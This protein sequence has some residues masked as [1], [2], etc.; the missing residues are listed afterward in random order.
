MTTREKYGLMAITVLLIIAGIWLYLWHQEAL[1][2]AIGNAKQQAEQDTQKLLDDKLRQR[3]QAYSSDRAQMLADIQTTQAHGTAAVVA[4]LNALLAQSGKQLPPI[5]IERGTTADKAAPGVVATD[6]QPAQKPAENVV[7]PPDSAS[8]LYAKA[9]H[10]DLCAKDLEHCNADVAD[11]KTKYETAQQAMTEQAN[12]RKGGSK[13]G[14]FGK[15][16]GCIGVSG[17]GAG[18]G[19]LLGKEKGAAIGG[20]IGAG[21]CQLI[22]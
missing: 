2:N 22:F 13:A 20:G 3:D 1:A 15:F 4:A 9:K 11:W 12:L 5:V 10:D 18:V 19:A 21:A 14:R 16:L 7:V 17:A 6:S 8:Y